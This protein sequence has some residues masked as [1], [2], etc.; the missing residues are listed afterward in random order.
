MSPRR[1]S[2]LRAVAAAV[3][4][5]G[6]QLY[7]PFLSNTYGPL[8]GLVTAVAILAYGWRF[9]GLV[10]GPVVLGLLP[11]IT[12]IAL[13]EVE[14]AHHAFQGTSDLEDGLVM[15]SFGVLGPAG[16][17]LATWLD[18]LTMNEV[19]FKRLRTFTR[20]APAL[21]VWALV[22]NGMQRVHTWKIATGDAIVCALGGLG[23]LVL[24]ALGKR[25]LKEEDVILAGI[26]AVHR[27]D[28]W[29]E[30]DEP[31]PIHHPPLAGRPKGA[32]VVFG[33]SPSK[34]SSSY[35]EAPPREFTVR[36]GMKLT[37]LVAM[38]RRAASWM[39]LGVAVLFAA[40]FKILATGV[41]SFGQAAKPQPPPSL[42]EPIH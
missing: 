30:I 40:S 36:E 4:V 31:A 8:V 42:G 14:R 17:A 18:G 37:H 6:C 25:A 19:R 9:G 3:V 27:G 15:V 32:V 23:F 20:Y 12:I 11:S 7:P 13:W 1:K 35:R 5:L 10:V 26:D 41:L 29:I 16:I 2:L 38:R 22:F 21:V 33:L 39:I 24:R 34:E 28:G